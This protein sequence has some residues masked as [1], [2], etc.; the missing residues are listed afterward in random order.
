MTQEDPKQK[1]LTL[2]L[3]VEEI[4]TVLSGLQEL[5]AKT[6]NPLT[7]K[8]VKQAQQQLPKEESELQ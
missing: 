1:I 6:C 8:I 7:N 2:E 5:P 4:N 3:S